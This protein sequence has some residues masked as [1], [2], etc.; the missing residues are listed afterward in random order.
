MELKESQCHAPSLRFDA[1]ILLFFSQRPIL[2]CFH[3]Y[4]A[5]IIGLE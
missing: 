4:N 1:L 2:R 5:D 3:L